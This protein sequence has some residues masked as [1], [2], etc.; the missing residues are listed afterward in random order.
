MGHRSWKIY[1][2]EG[3]HQNYDQVGGIS[4]DRISTVQDLYY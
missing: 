3:E 2:A 1:Q 4:N